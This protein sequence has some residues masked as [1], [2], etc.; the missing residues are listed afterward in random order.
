MTLILTLDRVIRHTVVYHSPTSVYRPNFVQKGQT[1]CGRTDV[2]TRAESRVK[3]HWV[4]DYVRVGSKLFWYRPGI[5]TRFLTEQ[6][7]DTASVYMLGTHERVQSRGSMRPLTQ[8]SKRELTASQLAPCPTAVTSRGRRCT[9]LPS[10]KYIN[11]PSR[12]P[13]RLIQILLHADFYDCRWCNMRRSPLIRV[14]IQTFGFYS[15]Q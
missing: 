12:L 3:G 8:S 11:N 7:N 14:V 2:R 9:T 15:V 4:S 1:F 13:H 5:L 6:R 10:S